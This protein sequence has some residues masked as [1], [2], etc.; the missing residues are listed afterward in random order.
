MEPLPSGLVQ[1]ESALAWRPRID[2]IEAKTPLS[3]VTRGPSAELL[4]VPGELV[5]NVHDDRTVA[6]FTGRW[7][8]ASK[9]AQQGMYDDFIMVSK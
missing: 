7:Q 3:A 9:V 5:S 2:E 1:S 4:S 8:R 6:A